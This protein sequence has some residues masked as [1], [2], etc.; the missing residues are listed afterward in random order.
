MMPRITETWTAEKLRRV[1]RKS[2]RNQ[3]DFWS[4]VGITQSGGSRYER[5]DR[6]ASKP[7]AILLDIAYGTHQSRR[8]TLMTLLP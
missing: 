1:R 5:G 8:T 4:V 6:T 7:V 3:R 2:L